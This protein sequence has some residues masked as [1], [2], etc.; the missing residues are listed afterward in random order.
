LESVEFALELSEP[1]A[2]T[3]LQTI[4]LRESKGQ[5]VDPRLLLLH[6]DLEALAAISK[7][8][9]ANLQLLELNA[10]STLPLPESLN[11]FRVQPHP[12]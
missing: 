12:R 10:V 11:R 6:L 8:R 3:R 9:V 2:D 1:F 7:H 4:V 5:R